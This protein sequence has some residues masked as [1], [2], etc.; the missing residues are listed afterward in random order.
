MLAKETDEPFSDKDWIYEIKWDGYRAIAE[1]NKND[2]NLYSRRGNT[3]NLSYPLI[4][5]ELKKLNI[6]AVLDGEIV[7]TDKNGKSDFQL[8]QQY[9]NNAN[10][11]IEFRVFDLLS[12]N[13]ENTCSLELT[14]RKKLLK[15]LLPKKN[16]IIKYSD[17][18]S[19]KGID[20]FKMAIKND[21]EGIMAKKANSLYYPGTRTSNWLKIKNHKS[22]EAVIA[23]FTEPTGGRKHLGALV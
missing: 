8:L 1:V 10:D 11:R 17:H 4:A 5:D 19:E 9:Q 3:F 23:G 16:S 15:L 22:Q 2:V 21:L 7:V 6:N 12:M 18:I 14:D 13:G 20:F